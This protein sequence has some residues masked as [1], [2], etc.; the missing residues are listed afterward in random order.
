VKTELRQPIG[1]LA[2]WHDQFAQ[3]DLTARRRRRPGQWV[4]AA[5][6]AFVLALLIKSFATSQNLEW[7]TVWS[8][9]FSSALL[10][11]VWVTIELSVISQALA[12]VLGFVLA[13]LRQSSNPFYSWFA[14]AYIFVFRGV[15]LLVQILFW[16]NLALVFPKLSFGVP[17]TSWHVDGSTNSIISPFLAS[18]LALAL[19]EAGYMAEIVRAGIVAVPRGQVEAA[20]S[21][22]L[23]PQA[24]LRKIVLPQTLR[25]VVPPT[26]NQFIGMLKASSLV[27]VIGGMELLTRAEEIYSVNFRIAALLIDVSMWYL[28]LVSVA[29]TGQ[30]YLERVLDRDRRELRPSAGPRSPLSRI[31]HSLASP[32]FRPARIDVDAEGRLG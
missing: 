23:T 27:S 28:F 11:G 21:I 20:L 24:A 22:G 2:G 25:V 10:H 6:G 17:F 13:A 3:E 5:A 16:Y 30:Y 29:S 15:P 14:A 8:F 9:L 31:A 7:G 19:A 32:P 4:A 12:I 1:G 18:I 26:G